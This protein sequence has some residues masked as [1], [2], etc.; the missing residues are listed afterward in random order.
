MRSM[1]GVYHGGRIKGSRCLA[2]ELSVFELLPPDI[3]KGSVKTDESKDL[4]L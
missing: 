4:C 3:D 2:E 1:F